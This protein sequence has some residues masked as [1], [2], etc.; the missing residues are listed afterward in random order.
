MLKAIAVLAVTM[1]VALS[2]MV[3]ICLMFAQG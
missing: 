3:G 2:P 1:G